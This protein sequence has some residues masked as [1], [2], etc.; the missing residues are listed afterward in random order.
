MINK[1]NRQAI[2]QQN[3]FTTHVSDQRFVS[4]IYREN[5]YK[6]VGKKAYNPI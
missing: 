3:I 5:S 4:I 2:D 1:I 6:Y